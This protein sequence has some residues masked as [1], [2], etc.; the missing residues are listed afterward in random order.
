MSKLFK[1]L[2]L[3]LCFFAVTAFADPQPLAILKQTSDAMI[4]ELDK[5]IGRLK[6]DDALVYSI[7]NRILLPHF[8]LVSMSRAVVGRDAW[9]EANPQ[10]QKEFISEFT[11][12]VIKTYAAAIASYDGETVKFHPLREDLGNKTR[13]QIDSSIIL[14]D[15]PAVQMQY[16][17]IQAGSTWLIYDFS[18]DGVSLVHNYQSQ[19]A[20][21]VRQGGLSKLIEQLKQ[22]NQA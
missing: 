4:K 10:Q 7:V 9:K 16:R 5:N 15:A 3:V 17:M 13:V 22:R 18:V 2:S 11:H 14:K 6:T 1:I 8:D 12:S 20:S 21:T 19:F